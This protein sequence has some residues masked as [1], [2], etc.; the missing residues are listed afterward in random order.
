MSF[1]NYQRVSGNFH[2]FRKNCHRT[3]A[4]LDYKSWFFASGNVAKDT[5][6]FHK[7]SF[8]DFH[9]EIL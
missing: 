6:I 5:F 2:L 1:G 3:F 8:E 9:I 4:F 7:V